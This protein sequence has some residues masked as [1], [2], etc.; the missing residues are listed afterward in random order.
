[1]KA[2]QRL[3]FGSTG[4]GQLEHVKLKLKAPLNSGIPKIGVYLLTDSNQFL[5]SNRNIF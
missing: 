3:H 2:K 5:C 1:M 4:T